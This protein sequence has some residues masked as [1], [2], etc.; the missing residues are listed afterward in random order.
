MYTGRLV[1]AAKDQMLSRKLPGRTACRSRY[2][3]GSQRTPAE[4]SHE[5]LRLKRPLPDIDSLLQRPVNGF[6]R[7]QK[8]AS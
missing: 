7:F 1:F 4:V 5:V 6:S 8:V 2:R 3:H